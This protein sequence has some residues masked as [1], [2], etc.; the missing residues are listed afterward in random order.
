MGRVSH[1]KAPAAD[2]KTVRVWATGQAMNFDGEA[3]P[4]YHVETGRRVAPEVLDL[5]DLGIR[6]HAR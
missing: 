1:S 5:V 6:D 3:V 4:A 2:L